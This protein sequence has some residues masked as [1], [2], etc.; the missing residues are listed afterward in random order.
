MP[1]PARQQKS[2]TFRLDETGLVD[3]ARGAAF[4]G[5]G[6]G[7]DP[8]IG[9]LMAQSAVAEHGFPAI[10]DPANL[11]D[12]AFVF[13]VAML[14]APTVLVEKAAAGPD[15]DL[16]MS[17]LEQ[18]FGRKAD[19]L[20]PAE[21]GGVNSTLP[22][23]AAARAGLPLINA[24]GMGRAFPEIQMTA[25]NFEGISPSPFVLVD[26]HLNSVMVE[27]ETAKKTESFVRGAAIEMGLSCVVAGYPMS[28]ADVKRATVHGTLTAALEIGRAIREGRRRGRAVETLID[29]LETLPQYGA[30]QRLFDA[31][32]VDLK[33]ETA[34]GFS[35]GRC[36]LENISDSS[37]RM[38]VDF[39]NENLSAVENGVLRAVVPD[40]VSIV[41]SE[42]AEPVPTEA[43]RYGQRVSVIATAAPEILRT[44]QA[45]EHVHPR[46]FGLPH[47]YAPLD[48][49]TPH[50]PRGIDGST[51]KVQF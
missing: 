18:R 45:L 23:M 21:I 9:R 3:F 44:P 17:R 30:A 32:I 49:R 15:V 39:Q 5:A 42:T 28:G 14:G 25:M 35:I 48:A 11:D 16:A 7:G 19:A 4:L 27:A 41:D 1:S 40:L 47:D 20:M 2:S 43:L 13:I 34:R 31:K 8:Y 50:E 36:V 37:R 38:E 6:G 51:G 46:C 24:D 29:C 33:R 12:D 22:I 26:E 10:I